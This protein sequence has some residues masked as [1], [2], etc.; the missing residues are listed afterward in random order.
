MLCTIAQFKARYGIVGTADDT[1]ITLML[2]GLSSS[3]ARATG[4]MIGDTPCL[5]LT[6]AGTDIVQTISP[7]PGRDCLPLATWPVVAVTSVSEAT[8]GAHAAGTVLAAADY[9]LHAARG[10]LYRVGLWLHG[11]A[12]VKV[13]YRGGY[14]PVG[15]VAGTGETAMPADIVEAMLIQAG[16]VWQRR[17]QL[18][19]GSK[20]LQQAQTTFYAQDD[21]LPSVRATMESYRRRML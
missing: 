2:E 3:L 20:G 4:R 9:Y 5:E 7:E 21:L 14:V 18:G 10:L 6:A 1:A 8:Y 17:N 16:Y 11:A 13:S 15:S 19:V 12:A